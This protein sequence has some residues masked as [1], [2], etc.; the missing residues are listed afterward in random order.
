V[1]ILLRGIGAG[2]RAAARAGQGQRNEARRR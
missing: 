2:N 1:D